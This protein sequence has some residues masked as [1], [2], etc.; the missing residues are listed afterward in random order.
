LNLATTLFSFYEGEPQIIIRNHTENICL[1]NVTAI[2]KM[3][4][5]RTLLVFVFGQFFSFS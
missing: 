4:Y 5:Q 1:F 3:L 2:G